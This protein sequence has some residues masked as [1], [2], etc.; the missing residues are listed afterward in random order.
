MPNY[1][2]S[3]IYKL[4]CPD[5]DPNDV[6]YGA[7]TQNLERRLS[8]HKSPINHCVSRL[9]FEKYKDKV[10]IELVE[11]FSCND[12]KELDIKEAYYIR[13]NNCINKV[14][15][16]RTDKEYY[17]EHKEQIS[18][19]NKEYRIEHKEYFKEY[20]KEYYI[21]HKEQKKEYYIE[22][23]EKL[24]EQSKEK[25][26]CECGGTYTRNNKSSHIKT[27]KHQEYILI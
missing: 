14:I 27:K 19:K 1:Q 12:K 23:K 4:Y 5:G 26:T 3:K 9:L 22:H 6:Y 15:P 17:I 10:K 11:N 20:H 8:K 2:N 16:N 7:T 24:L 25:F 18:E 21:E 13:N